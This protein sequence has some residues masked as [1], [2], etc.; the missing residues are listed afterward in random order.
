[1]FDSFIG[2]NG[3]PKTPCGKLD[4]ASLNSMSVGYG[5]DLH[6]PLPGVLSGLSLG[7]FVMVRFDTYRATAP[8]TKPGSSGSG[9]ED[10]S[11]IGLGGRWGAHARWRF[12]RPERGAHLTLDLARTSRWAPKHRSDFLHYQ[13]ALG[14]RW[15]GVYA[16]VEQRFRSVG[17]DPDVGDFARLYAK[18]N[19][20]KSITSVGLSL[21]F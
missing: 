17:G 8:T 3:E 20:I 15:F 13:A 2:L 18:N 10:S 5:L 21:V 4:K 19:G 1:M 9:D 6:P 16:S 7:P 12:G 14:Y 11:A